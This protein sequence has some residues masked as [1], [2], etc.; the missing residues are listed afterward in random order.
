MANKGDYPFKR[1]IERVPSLPT[2][3]ANHANVYPFEDAAWAQ[4]A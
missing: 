2:T 3:N 1:Q 4:D